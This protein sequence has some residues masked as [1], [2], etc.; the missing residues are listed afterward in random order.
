MPAAFMLADVVVHASTRAEAFGRVVIEAQAMQRP[1]IASDLGGPAETVTHAE[2]G[3]LVPP[4]Q[5]SALAA[6]IERVLSLS[7]QE[8]QALGQR[9]REAVLRHNTVRAMQQ[10]TLQVYQE[11]LAA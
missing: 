5:P 6:A 8:R 11:L 1:V 10:A 2:T 3:W 9:A 4:A 7:E